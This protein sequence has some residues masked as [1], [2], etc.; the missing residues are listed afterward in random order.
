MD[1][2]PVAVDATGA[3]WKSVGEA[4]SWTVDG[5]IVPDDVVGA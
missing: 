5:T 1:D 4:V 2:T 3:F